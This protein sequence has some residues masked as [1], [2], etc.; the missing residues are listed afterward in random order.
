MNESPIL[1]TAA[2]GRILGT[3][4][5]PLTSVDMAKSL[6]VAFYAAVSSNAKLDSF[7]EKL[8][9]CLIESEV[10]IITY[11]QALDEG[12]DGRIG[13]G[14]VLIAPGE[15]ETGNLAIDHVASL[16]NNTVVAVLGGKHPGLGAGALQERVDALVS[17]LVWHMAH[18]IIYIDDTTWTVCNMNGAID[19]Y[20]HEALK[21]RVLD[22]LIPKLAAP[23]V[24]RQKNEFEVEECP[25]DT[26]VPDY[27]FQVRDML[28]G[29]DAWGKT[30]LLAAQT[31]MAE[32]E[33]RTERYRRIAAAFL[34]YRTG[35]SYGFLARQL[36]LAATPAVDLDDGPPLIRLLDWAQNDFYEI[37]GHVCVA[38][39]L[40]NK[41]YLVRVPQVSVICTRSGC[42]KT[43][44]DPDKDLLKLSLVDGRILIATPKDSRA[45]DDCQP[46]FDILTIL[47]H[48]VGNAIVASALARLRSSS[49]F[50]TMLRRRGL[51]L[52]HWHGFV[53]SSELPES[54]HLH[55]LTNPPVSCS[56]PQ[57]AIF[58]LS[59]KL[60]A[61]Q[62]SLEAG[63][64]Y[65]GDVHVEPSHGTNITG[66]SLVELAGL[67]RRAGM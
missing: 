21:D 60:T 17:G 43:Q 15:G 14:I 57:A 32:L 31:K 8:R 51:A 9:V 28:S 3:S 22:S 67:V 38:L 33:F 1:S 52:A 58:A 24:P 19:T 27:E 20:S 63:I 2:M 64:D 39:K 37:E 62:Q 4:P 59:G 41:R 56:T 49:T 18:V 50:H 29:S 54:Y 7:L 40:M 23:V 10:N 48:A 65:L 25:F 66:N 30:G 44:L 35:M 55:G 12:S 45:E 6:R 13:K 53:H 36:P 34:S 47:A 5:V 11:Q 26:S 61:L 42:K 16:S 46:S